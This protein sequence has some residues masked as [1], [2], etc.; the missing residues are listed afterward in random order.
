MKQLIE[1]K[2]L[3]SFFLFMVSKAVLLSTQPSWWADYSLVDGST[4]QDTAVATHGQAKH[5]V[6]KAYQYLEVELSEIGGAGLAVTTLYTTYCTSA[7]TDAANDRLPL[8]I[9]QL[10]YLAKPFYDHLNSAAADF[11]TSAMNPASTD[12]Y[13]WTVEQSDDA[14]RAL[15]TL[16]Q[17]K[18]V[19]SFDLSLWLS[20]ADDTDRDNILDTWEQAIIDADPEDVISTIA[21]VQP[22]D[23]YD[24]DGL[25]N[26]NEFLQGSNPLT[27]DHPALELMLY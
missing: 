16:G 12:I 20:P 25:N 15:A 10:K 14:D 24:A 9:G 17:L 26:Q 19:F 8:S 2:Y 7:P 6:Q 18:F 3:A 21:D 13:P 1:Q 23:D 27:N 22:E 4:R 5:A 11:D